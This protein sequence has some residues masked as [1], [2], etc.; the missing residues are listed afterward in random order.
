MARSGT[1]VVDQPPSDSSFDEDDDETSFEEGEEEEQ[2]V[3]E[4]NGEDEEESESEG[5]E[6]ENPQTQSS[7]ATIPKPKEVQKPESSSESETDSESGNE[8]TIKPIL[9]QKAPEASPKPTLDDV[10]KKKK[11]NKKEDSP[12]PQEKKSLGN[13]IFSDHDQIALLQGMIAYQSQK[14][15][16]PY[17]DIS[18]FY[19]FVKDALHVAVSK[20]QV[21]EKIRRLKIKFLNNCQKGNASS[22]SNP[23]DA[24][25]FSLSKEIWG[26]GGVAVEQNGGKGKRPLEVKNASGSNKKTV[27]AP[28]DSPKDVSVKKKEEKRKARK[29]EENVE[30]KK[31]KQKTAQDKLHIAATKDIQTTAV[32]REDTQTTVVEGGNYQTDGKGNDK[33][34]AMNGVAEVEREKGGLDF[35]SKYPHF[36]NSFTA[37]YYP[38]TP[39][40]ALGR[41][42]EK[43]TLLDCSVA[44]KLEKK[45]VNVWEE[46]SKLG[47]M[48]ADLVS[49]QARLVRGEEVTL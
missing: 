3:L 37:K 11:K 30:K 45:W 21:K 22:S 40:E 13:R 19:D 26:P 38:L 12:K 29:D 36:L 46:Y 47:G 23:T 33:L 32:E 16:D 48:I 6:E 44:E 25:I 49:L 9:Y 2:Q 14:G 41:W 24:E 28:L 17:S 8:F 5:E 10:G 7:P 31:K 35:L 43:A 15:A 18:G 20:A 39:E 27:E 34:V 42:K 1:R 4:G